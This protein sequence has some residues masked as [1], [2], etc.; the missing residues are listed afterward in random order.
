MSDKIV[1]IISP[2]TLVAMRKVEQGFE[3]VGAVMARVA[4][5]IATYASISRAQLNFFLHDLY[6]R[7]RP[8][9]VTERLGIFGLRSVD[10][11]A[12]SLAERWEY[13]EWVLSW[14]WRALVRTGQYGRALFRRR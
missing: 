1:F 12:L 11:G 3:D 4:P 8:L 5:L 13:Q 6:P 10:P 9:T 14:P 2:E 7:S